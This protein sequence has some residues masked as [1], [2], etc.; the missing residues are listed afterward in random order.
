MRSG[1]SLMDNICRDATSPEPEG[2]WKKA[3]K[4]RMQPP[5][6]RILSH[7]MVY[8]PNL[9]DREYACGARRICPEM[10]FINVTARPT[11]FF[12]LVNEGLR[13]RSEGIGRFP[14]TEQRADTK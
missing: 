3:Q 4:S 1:S 12:E 7:A 9:D 11:D 8:S 13:S 5:Q 14:K 2:S 6:P 10:F